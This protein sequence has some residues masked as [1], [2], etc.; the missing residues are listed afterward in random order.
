MFHDESPY[1]KFD[2]IGITLFIPSI[3]TV[4]WRSV[5]ARQFDAPY[6]TMLVKGYYFGGKLSRKEI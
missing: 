2:F 3:V 6:R 4:V 5:G 1:M